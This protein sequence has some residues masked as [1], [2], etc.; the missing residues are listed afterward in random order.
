[1]GEFE[2]GLATQEG[3][4]RLFLERLRSYPCY[5]GLDLAAVSDLTA[6]V[7]AWPIAD[8]VY[9][10]PWFW[11]PE[12]DIVGRSKRDNVRYDLWARDGY[13]ELTSGNVTDWRFCTA[14]IKQLA[15]IFKIREIG[16]DRAGARDTVSDLMDARIEVV[17]V[18]QGFLSM[19]APAK[20][21]EELTLSHKLVHTGHPVLRWNVDCATVDQDPAG[22]IKP[23]KP[24]RQKGSKRIDGVV[25]AVIALH[26]VQA[27]I[28]KKKSVYSTRGVVTIA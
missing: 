7:L 19:S 24:N 5:G 11:I 3:L 14:R 12:E 6:L 27:A 4:G 28:P 22:N 8:R 21:L 25:A 10:Y 9:L 16:F 23:V 2:I 18:G 17:D 15:H 1:M 26:R 13:I 20:R